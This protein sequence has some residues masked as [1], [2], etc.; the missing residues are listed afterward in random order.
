MTAIK[1]EYAMD[2]GV[3]AKT[4]VRVAASTSLCFMLLTTAHAEVKEVGPTAAEEKVDKSRVKQITGLWVRGGGQLGELS[5]RIQDEFGIKILDELSKEQAS[6]LLGQLNNE[7][8]RKAVPFS[9][10]PE[11]EVAASPLSCLSLLYHGPAF[12]KEAMPGLVG[13][14]VSGHTGAAIARLQKWR[15]RDP[16]SPEVHYGLALAHSAADDEKTALYH[17]QQALAAGLP[18]GRFLAGP[19]DLLAKLH[20]TRGFRKIVDRDRL[21]LVHGPSVGAVTDQSAKFWVRTAAEAEVA[22]TVRPADAAQGGT[23]AR[24]KTTKQ[25]DWT[26]VLEVAG[27]TADTLYQ[28]SLSVNGKSVLAETDTTF[29]TFPEAGKGGV[30]SVGFGSKSGYAPVSENMWDA[31]RQRKLNAFLLLGDNLFVHGQGTTPTTQRYACYRRQSSPQYRRF[32]ASTP[33]YA[34]WDDNDFGAGLAESLEVFRQ[35]HANPSFGDGGK[36]SGIW[37]T[38]AIGDVTFFMLDCSSQRSRPKGAAATMLGAAQKQWLLEGLK[39]S[40]ATFKVIA[41][42]VPWAPSSAWWDRKRTWDS[43]AEERE[44]IFSFIESNRIEGVVLLS[45]GALNA[46]EVRRIPRSEGYHLYDLHSSRLTNVTEVMTPGGATLNYDEGRSF[47]VLEFDTTRSTPRLTYRTV[48]ASGKEVRNH[49]FVLRPHDLDFEGL[50]EKD[51]MAVDLAFTKR[52]L[53]YGDGSLAEQGM[54]KV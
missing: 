52:P 5:A 43:S 33:V 35:N 15:A 27:L 11:V 1:G 47:G 40:D 22:V 4:V 13:Q 9:P 17:A 3:H 48:D 18:L 42:P 32:T 23:E 38:F 34:I 26:A 54:V 24:G 2:H 45:G 10:A 21:L 29:R 50:P 28:Y 44:E 14:L 37:F 31:V 12:Y 19:R 46:T 7:T 49:D 20:K 30:F 25:R 51:G 36:N 8:K 39:N 53:V 6:D 16:D 41:S